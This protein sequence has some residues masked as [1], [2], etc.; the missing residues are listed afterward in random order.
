[1]ANNL[2]QIILEETKNF[3][4]DRLTMSF[5]EIMN[6]Y[7]EGE[8]NINPD[9]QRSFRWSKEKQ[10]NLIESILLGI[11]IPPIFVAENE[12]GV[13]E[14]VDGLQ[15]IS[16]VLSFFA[17]LENVSKEKRTLV[18]GKGKLIPQLEDVSIQNMSFKLKLR[19]KRATVGV[20]VLNR[21]SDS[22]MK[23]ELFKRLNT[24]SEGL[25]EQE[26]RNAI[27]S[28]KLNTYINQLASHDTFVSLMKP[29]KKQKESMYLSELVLRYLAFKNS[30]DMK[31]G[32]RSHLDKYMEENVNT[33]NFDEDKEKEEFIKIIT[34]INDNFG[35]EIFKAKNGQVTKN[36]YDSLTY[37]L[38][39]KFDKYQNNPRAKGADPT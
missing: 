34:Y 3:R 11:P 24:T 14:L 6:M 35:T 37:V 39:E 23:Y 12:D 13:W 32:V 31:D 29:T 28:G 7:K 27:Y 33:N 2:E 4:T 36:L 30:I 10:T 1:M 25:S 15:R 38:R 17:I 16:T 22:Q 18:L 9:F 5:G 19:I 21:D 26:M 20:E 8:I